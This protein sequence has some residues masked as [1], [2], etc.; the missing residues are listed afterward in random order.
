MQFPLKLEFNNEEEY[1]AWL[2]RTDNRD[3][4][5]K[6]YFSSSV[7]ATQKQIIA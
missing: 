2:L 5:E 7:S 4:I 6:V 1:K 3:Y